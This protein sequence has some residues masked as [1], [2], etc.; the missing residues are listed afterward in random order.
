MIEIR[1]S[2][3]S[4]DN[5]LISFDGRVLEFFSIIS[6]HTTRIHVFEIANIEIV[7][8]KHG[9]CSL[10]VNSKYVNELILGGQT[11]R[12]EVLPETQALVAAVRQ[13]MALYP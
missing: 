9:R 13:A 6:R 8:D 11:V 5:T 1:L 7:V 10:N 3:E 12:S 4:S 2:T